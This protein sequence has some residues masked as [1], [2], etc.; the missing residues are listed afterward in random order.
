M[1]S[2][3][4][5]QE[6]SLKPTVAVLHGDA[7]AAAVVDALKS[8]RKEYAPSSPYE[9]MVGIVIRVVQVKTRTLPGNRITIVVAVEGVRRYTDDEYYYEAH[10]SAGE[11]K[12]DKITD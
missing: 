5:R 8:W 12:L 9:G 6:V 10:L 7:Y 1:A 4:H 2:T 3:D 11:L